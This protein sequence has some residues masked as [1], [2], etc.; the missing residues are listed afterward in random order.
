[1]Q[2][3][4]DVG[5][6]CRS[7][8]AVAPMSNDYQLR[9]PQ[10]LLIGLFMCAGLLMTMGGYGF[11]RQEA[12]VI[13][14]DMP[15]HRPDPGAVLVALG[16]LMTGGSLASFMFSHNS[17]HYQ[18]A[19]ACAEQARRKA[20]EEARATL[21]GIG[22][23]VIATDAAGAITRM[24]PAASRLSGWSEAEALGRPIHEVFRTLH[25]ATRAEAENLVEA[26]LHAGKRVGPVN[27]L[28]LVAKDGAER[29]I[30]ERATPIRGERGK[31]L[32][33]ALV[34][35]DETA[36]RV[37]RE[38]LRESEARYRALFDRSMDAVYLHDLEGRFLDANPAA[39]DALGYTR[40]EIPGLNFASL[41]TNE[42]DLGRALQ[43]MQEIVTTGNQRVVSEYQL[44]RKDG[45][46]VWFELQGSLVLNDGRP[47]A[48][49]GVGRNITERKRAEESLLMTQF[50]VEHA[51][52]AL[53]WMTFESRIV[54]VNETACR[55]LGY[56][57]E[58]LLRL[59]VPDIDPDY[60]DEV[61]R[62]AWESLKAHHTMTIET[63]HRTKDGRILPVEI[64]ASHIAFGGKEYSCAFVRDIT[65]RKRAEAALRESEELCRSL[66]DAIPQMA[67]VA[68][69]DGYI[70]WYNQRWYEYTGTTPEQMAGWGWQSVHHP[71]TLPKVLER[72]RH[73]IAT[74]EPFDMEFPLRGADGRFRPFLTRIYPVRNSEGQIVQW[75]GTNTDI[76]EQKQLEAALRAS[77]ARHA[78]MVAN[79]GDVIAIID[80]DGIN[81]Y[82]SPNIERWFGW[83]PEEVV[84]RSTW[85]NV[86]PDDLVNT[87]RKFLEI[88]SAPD[89]TGSAELRYRCK[90]GGYKWIEFTGVNL[91][92]DPSIQGVLLNYRD[93]TERKRVKAA[94]LREKEF[95]EAIFDS[96]PGIIYLYDDQCRL[97]RWN[98]R[99]E[100]LTG[101]TAD[102]LSR[103]RLLDWYAG[104]ENALAIVQ[105]GLK[106]T[107]EEGYGH[108]EVEMQ[109]KDGSRMP[110][111][112]TASPLMIDG[113]SY[114][115]GI[116]IDIT[117]HRRVEE[118]KERLQAQ[119]LQAQKMESVGRLAGGVA[120][121]FNNMLGVIIG[122]AEMALEE[123]EPA[124]PL[125]DDL[126]EIQKAAQRS[127]DL[128]RQLL[129]FAR[130]QTVSPKVLNMN[131]TVAGMIQMLR[132][133]I[134][135][136]IELAWRP[137]PE[138]WP[139]RMD[140][141]QLDQILANLAVNA[142][143]AISGVGCVTIETKNVTFDQ[144]C[145]PA[146]ADRTPGEY[147]LLKLSD[148]GAG[149]D[150]ETLEHLFEPFFTT[151]EV[152]KGTGLG[153]ATVYGAVKQ[154]LGFIEVHSEP[155]QGSTFKIYLPLAEIQ[156]AVGA[157]ASN[158]P[159]AG[160]ETVLLVEDEEAILRLSEM[161]LTKHGYE[162]L[163]AQ[164]PAE[165]LEL[166]RQ[167]EGAIHLLITD[168][169]MPEMNGRELKDRLK[170][171]R[172]EIKV[173]FMSGYTSDVI[174]HQ[175]V[176]EEG[177]AFL[178]KPFT[179]AS[180]AQKVREVMQ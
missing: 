119:L 32:G 95:T 68:R 29:P 14:T 85:E 75:V 28:L 50:S 48:V 63:R 42:Q 163:A 57:R 127:A 169:V 157:G 34:F 116:G 11:H 69:P 64:T 46:L 12:Q 65:E 33:V 170:A 76:T 35:R 166:A 123:V 10:R 58:E 78:K 55:T 140:P 74:G 125:H 67:A 93:V 165:A 173:L 36:E 79:I 117:E 138:L 9:I 142:R 153:L 112:L 53:Y 92:H 49:L 151:K 41:L 147:V 90:D 71:E 15:K 164:S 16:M 62:E 175:G 97:V 100:E 141:S 89:A 18:R 1:M 91:L 134:G 145:C 39:L 27:H 128:T 26:V 6:P 22:D 82:K 38:S 176:I 133:L 108:A 23:G 70:H 37:T 139:V 158:P 136:N 88:L 177:V 45:E 83:K 20:E 80:Q 51:A 102:E 107:F 113:K 77:E 171:L 21:Y 105:A 172:P 155:G 7:D 13:R 81:R 178:Q 4:A 131:E 160:S 86:H 174:A 47:V 44:R 150:K 156:A 126:Q 31:T 84:G 111:Y 24:N 59:T 19:L 122:H 8:E 60:N 146:H 168:V 66:I 144:G 3:N 103:I 162:V 25:E 159:A 143:D 101:Y 43:T 149:M 2:Q 137:G 167:Y 106:R 154:N 5:T 72:W 110:M 56:T 152:G 115:V 179:V 114:F 52:D 148:T 121:D 54:S 130:K 99:H 61:W 73:T 124:S 109:R 17:K 40:E 135:E 98:K 180:L 94:L 104:D 129:A 96:T 120:H 118:E 161:I 30:T 87:Q 132:R